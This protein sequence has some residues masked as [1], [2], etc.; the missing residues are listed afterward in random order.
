MA[1]SLGI[2]H[3]H[4]SSCAIVQDGRPLAAMQ[5]ERFTRRKADGQ[6]ALS[7]DLPLHPCLKAA[8]VA[9]A[10]VDIIVSSFQSV[11]PGGVGL[12][13]PLVERGF[14]L[15]DPNDER[16]HVISHHLAHL[17]C[18]FGAS[19]FPSAAGIICDLGGSS[20]LDGLDFF[21]SYREWS[22]AVSNESPISAVLKTECLSIYEIDHGTHELKKREFVIPHN[23]PEVYVSSAASLYDNVSRFIFNSED[24][25]GQLMALA[26]LC[27]SQR[28]SQLTVGDLVEVVDDLNVRFKND[29]QSCITR[30]DDPLYHVDLARIT[31][32]ALERAV[33]IY[34]ETA[35]RLT[36]CK[37]LV[38][39]GGTFLNIVVNS[40][41]LRQGLFDDV[42]IPSAPHDAGI[43]LG[44]AYAGIGHLLGS[45]S[46]SKQ[47]PDRLGCSYDISMIDDVCADV[48]IQRCASWISPRQVAERLASGQIVARVAGRSEFGPRA[49]GA[50]SLLGS[51]CFASIK[52]RMNLIKGRQTWR[53]VAPITLTNAVGRFFDGP[54]LSPYMN[55][56][57][58]IRTEFASG[59]PALAH[60]DGSTR[61]QTL[62]ATSDPFLAEVLVEFER[63]TGF[64]ILV[65]TSLNGRGQPIIESPTEALEFFLQKPDIDQLLI[66][67]RMISRPPETLIEQA[68]FKPNTVFT[69]LQVN[70]KD[71]VLAVRGQ[72]STILSMK[73]FHRILGAGPIFDDD[74]TEET[75]QAQLNDAVRGGICASAE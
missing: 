10:D 17:H 44:C 41:I 70:G 51:P 45:S 31:Q 23:A 6:E 69:V 21:T 71:Q 57:H 43:S 74:E 22:T 14:D 64:P 37:M 33:E 19:G 32:K 55:F 30:H 13:R 39:A 5:Q 26:S 60:P 24:A 20:T 38:C 29:W 4:H 53:P 67:E 16:H 58:R 18:A 36:S 25:H 73:A 11:A 7:N 52:D 28:T 34:V 1:L 54:A 27:G 48:R 75:T 8:G 42:Y 63:L 65:N 12:T 15:F 68:K 40:A 9:L 59:L 35:R 62:E 66:E 46:G 61:V 47:I 72:A 56:V 3:G 49:L 2:H 50:R